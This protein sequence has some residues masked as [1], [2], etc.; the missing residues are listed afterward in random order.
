M[1]FVS[2][3]LAGCA[4][5]TRETCIA[6]RADAWPAIALA[7]SGTRASLASAGIV[8]TP[9]ASA[10][11]KQVKYFIGSSPSLDMREHGRTAMNS[12]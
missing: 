2:F 9:V 11:V 1:A 3:A 5:R 6:E 12:Q 8:T 7:G 4:A 10:N